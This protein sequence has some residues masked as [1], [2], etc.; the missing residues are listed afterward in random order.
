MH[1]AYYVFSIQISNGLTSDVNYR[2]QVGVLHEG[3]KVT[4]FADIGMNCLLDGYLQKIS[5]Q[6]K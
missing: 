2:L 1:V 4:L 6:G 3:G 5:V